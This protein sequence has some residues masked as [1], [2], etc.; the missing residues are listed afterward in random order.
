M[1]DIKINCATC[2]DEFTWDV[3]QQE[4]YQ[5]VGL[6]NQPRHCPACRQTRKDNRAPRQMFDGAVCQTCGVAVSLPFAPKPDG[7][8][9]C[10]EHY[11]RK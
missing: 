6:T 8:Y 9:F 2:G 11:V 5:K 4:Y 3:A 10:R 1:E 7:K